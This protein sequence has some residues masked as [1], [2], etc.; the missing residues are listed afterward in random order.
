MDPLSERR[1]Q[2]LQMADLGT[3]RREYIS[4]VDKPNRFANVRLE[5]VEASRISNRKGSDAQLM[6]EKNKAKL[7]AWANVYQDIGDTGDLED[8]DRLMDGQSHR[9]QL[10]A[11]IREH[12]GQAYANSA[13]TNDNFL[14]STGNNQ[15]RDSRH[16]GRGGGIIG[17]RG[18]MSSLQSSP[19]RTNNQGSVAKLGHHIPQTP[20]ARNRPLDPAVDP[21]REYFLKSKSRGAKPPAQRYQ[22]RPSNLKARRPVIPDQNYE[23]LLADPQGFL[24]AVR[25]RREDS[26]A[27][28]SQK[29]TSIADSDSYAQE[30]AYRKPE[31]ESNSKTTFD[32]AEDVPKAAF[33]SHEKSVNLPEP[34]ISA[35]KTGNK[36]MEP[37]FASEGAQSE[38]KKMPVKPHVREHHSRHGSQPSTQTETKTQNLLKGF[39]SNLPQP[40]FISPKSPPS[41]KAVLKPTPEEPCGD[42]LLDFSSAPSLPVE[43]SKASTFSS[44]Q[45]T[46]PLPKS[47]AVDDLMDIDFKQSSQEPTLSTDTLS[48]QPPAPAITTQPAAMASSQASNISASTIN[49][50]AIAEYLKEISMLNDLVANSPLAGALQDMIKQRKQ[51]LEAKI[52]SALRTQAASSPSEAP[53][54]TTGKTET[55]NFLHTGAG[56][57]QEVHQ[58]PLSATKPEFNEQ[59]CSETTQNTPTIRDTPKAESPLQKAVTAEPFVPSSSAWD[60]R[61]PRKIST[62][63]ESESPGSSGENI[64]DTKSTII[65]DHLLPGR[66]GTNISNSTARP[67]SASVQMHDSNVDYLCQTLNE[68]LTSDLGPSVGNSSTVFASSQHNRPAHQGGTQAGGSVLSSMKPPAFEGF[69]TSSKA[70]EQSYTKAENKPFSGHQEMGTNDQDLFKDSRIAS[71]R[72][73]N[74]ESA[75]PNIPMSAATR[76]YASNAS[77]TLIQRQTSTHSSNLPA[78]AAP[79]KYADNVFETPSK[80]PGHTTRATPNIPMS[81]ATRQ[82]ASSTN[83]PQSE[84]APQETTKSP[85]IPLSAATQQYAVNAPKSAFK[86]LLYPETVTPPSS[87][88]EQSDQSAHTPITLSSPRTGQRNT[89][90]QRNDPRKV[91]GLMA[92]KYA[93]PY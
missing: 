52:F 78:S 8:L 63:S 29:S 33:T 32:V 60:Y 25:S 49:E 77:A 14:R 23:N 86:K 56:A 3:A 59:K 61:S 50:Q 85:N 82:Y 69:F 22:S 35:A 39:T 81:A 26:T 11:T 92:S 67:A 24:A 72:P 16:R 48:P 17:T 1:L 41:K 65:G 87:V 58:P 46:S 18:R 64:R 38:V 74:K 88:R 6:A 57:G 80:G 19:G 70:A 28:A 21:D 4:T 91:S 45:P 30:S 66:H 84:R 62:S 53:I 36:T 27:S 15:G 89:S 51:E 7:A 31:T 2:E 93:D 40:A 42:L 79:R 10:T 5:E 37:L 12:G 34:S 55:E 75:F 90:T 54:K 68:W 43:T 13:A 9:A 76:Q 83:P 71:S 20:G 73:A 44:Q 47:P